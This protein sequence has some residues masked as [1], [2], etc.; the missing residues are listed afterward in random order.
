MAEGNGTRI[1][2]EI[3]TTSCCSPSPS[4]SSNS[5]PFLYTTQP[6]TSQISHMHHQQQQHQQPQAANHLPTN[7]N[8]RLVPNN[9][10]HHHHNNHNNNNHHHQTLILQPSTTTNPIKYHLI[11][12][13]CSPTPNQQQQQPQHQTHIFMDHQ[14]IDNNLDY[15]C[16]SIDAVAAV[17]PTHTSPGSPDQQ[18]CSSTTTPIGD[19]CND[20]SLDTKEDLIPRRLCLVCGDVA[21]GF[22]YGVAS[23]EACKAFFKRTIQGV[24]YCVFFNLYHIF[25]F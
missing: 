7:S 21:S 15:K 20:M 1:K 17:T 22:H 16:S 25:L 19:M 6:Q 2:Q 13:P 14:Q 9:D 8:V 4:T 5:T 18:F 12:S 24:Y 10:Q 3:D 11:P 23:C